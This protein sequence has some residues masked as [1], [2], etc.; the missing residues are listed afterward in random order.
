MNGTTDIG[1]YHRLQAIENS[2]V[3]R[4]CNTVRNFYVV[5]N[6]NAARN[7]DVVQN[8]NMAGNIQRHRSY[9]ARTIVHNT[10]V[11]IFAILISSPLW[12]MLWR[13]A[14]GFD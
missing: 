5:Q 4:N 6:C 3:V 10:W 11:T 12:L 1:M 9:C 7:F 8:S 13:C 14:G 2:N